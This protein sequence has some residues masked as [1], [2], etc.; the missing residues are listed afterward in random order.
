M[1]LPAVGSAQYPTQVELRDAI[2]RTIKLGYQRRGLSANVLHGSDHWYRADSFSRRASVAIANNKL[3]LADYTPLTAV[4]DALTELAGVFGVSRRDSAGATGYVTV[5][6]TGSAT[7]PSGFQCTAADGHKYQTTSANF[8]TTT[9][10]ILVQAVE[11]GESTNKDEGDILTWD[12]GAI[13]NL[14]PTCVVSDSALDGGTDDE[15]DSNL[16]ARLIE[17]ISFP[18]QGGTWSQVQAWAEEASPSVAAAFVYQAVRGPGSY[19]VAIVGASGDRELSPTVIGV[20]DNYLVG[21]MPGP[22]K[23]NVTSVNP[24]EID[25]ILDI[26]VPL[27]QSVGGAGGGFLDSVPWP[28]V[29]TKVDSFI[30]NIAT[31]H[32]S[33]SPTVGNRIGIWDPDSETM[34]EYTISYVSGGIGMWDFTVQGGFI[35]NPE[36]AYISAGCQN[37]KDYAATIIEKMIDLGPGEKSASTG[38]LPHGARQPGPDVSS[39]YKLTNLV[40]L[41]LATEFAEV[42]DVDILHSYETLTTTPRTVPSVPATTADPPNILVLKYLAFV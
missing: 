29:A 36:N 26:D 32:G 27:P 33:V 20:V 9:G 38:I 10:D 11:T 30:T 15:S 37:L 41:S 16:R 13:G 39:P 40:S 23:A 42:L 25:L 17:K 1:T 28:T 35:A 14:A 22:M 3:A 34:H 2:L 5:T 24:E 19:D 7:I 31:C 21:K 8:V 4:E 6:V 12:S 18:G